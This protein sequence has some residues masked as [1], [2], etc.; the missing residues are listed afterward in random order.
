MISAVQDYIAQAG[1]EPRPGSGSGNS[2][3][4]DARVDG[5]RLRLWFGSKEDPLV[6]RSIDLT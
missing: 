3:D 4:P 1:A 2:A 5:D 6:L